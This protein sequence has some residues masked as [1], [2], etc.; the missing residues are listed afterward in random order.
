MRILYVVGWGRT[1]ST[2]LD[3]MLG[4]LPGFFSVGELRGIW[5][6]GV[7][8]DGLCGCGESFHRCPFWREVGRA[9]FGGWSLPEANH[10]ARVQR[11]HDRVWQVP[12][13]V[14]EHA[15]G[16]RSR[17]LAGYLSVLQRLYGAVEAISGAEVIVDSSKSPSFGAMLQMMEPMP[18]LRFLHL[19]RDSR[20]VVYSWGKRTVVRPGPGDRSG[21]MKSYSTTSAALRY[22]VW[23]LGAHQVK[24]IG[25]SYRRVRYEDLLR[26]PISTLDDLARYAGG[27][28]GPDDFSFIE[29]SDI[30]LG[31]SHTL[32]GNPMRFAVGSVLLRTDEVWKQEMRLSDRLTTTVLTLPLLVRY[33]YPISLMRSSS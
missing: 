27:A 32:D 6:R 23:N 21:L 11:A 4:Q 15:L 26:I 28:L 7:I 9:A 25:G 31:T 17:E 16:Y 18:D 33:G 14:G 1:G 20:G 30:H 22:L 19:V 29:G 10:M 3:R 8:E 5:S 13:L 12:W 2:L 24:L